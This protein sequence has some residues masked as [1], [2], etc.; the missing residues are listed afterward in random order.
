MYTCLSRGHIS[1]PELTFVG[2]PAGLPSVSLIRDC[3]PSSNLSRVPVYSILAGI[4][5]T[6]LSL[7]ASCVPCAFSFGN[8][9]II[10]HHLVLYVE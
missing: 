8:E 2:E 7:Q 4:D 10:Y 3:L 6:F 5:K 1:D 9:E